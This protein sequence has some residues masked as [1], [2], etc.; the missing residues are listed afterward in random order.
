METTGTSG[1][2]MPYWKNRTNVI[3]PTVQTTPKHLKR[4]QFLTIYIPALTV[5]LTVKLILYPKA[6]KRITN[7]PLSTTQTYCQPPPSLFLFPPRSPSP[8]SPNPQFFMPPPTPP[9]FVHASS[10]TRSLSS[11]SPRARQIQSELHFP[12]RRREGTM[13]GVRIVILLHR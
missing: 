5:Y 1:L 13:T 10:S 9:L 3:L 4:F 12:F 8:L 2:S 6:T 11:D 7:M